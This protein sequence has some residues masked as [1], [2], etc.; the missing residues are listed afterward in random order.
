MPVLSVHLDLD[1]S[2]ISS[3]FK[4]IVSSELLNFYVALVASLG[5]QINLGSWGDLK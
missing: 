1:A 4:C 2:L 5:S 3:W